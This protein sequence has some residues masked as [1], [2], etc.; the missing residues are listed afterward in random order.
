MNKTLMN[1]TQLKKVLIERQR[2]EATNFSLHNR[3][4]KNPIYSCLASATS[5][6]KI[7]FFRL[8]L[9]R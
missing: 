6:P 4:Q 7:R 5:N 9:R 2:K 8:L 1:I 3:R